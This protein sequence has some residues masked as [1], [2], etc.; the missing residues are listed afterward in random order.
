MFNTYITLND[1][2]DEILIIILKKLK[3]F[4]IVYSLQGINQR[5]NKLIQ[6]RIFTSHLT[7]VKW[8]SDNFI[9]LISCEM[10]LNRF[11]L[12]ILPSIQHKIEWLDLES[13]SMNYILGAGNYPNLH[14]LGLFNINEESTRCLFTDKKVSSDIFKN[15]IRRL[16]I[17][18][19]N[20]NITELA[21]I[22]IFNYILTIFNNLI[23]LTLYESSY[24][25]CVRLCFDNPPPS[26][27]C[28]ST[29]LKLNIKVQWF[30]D[31]LYILD[32]RF[33]QLHTLIVD[34][35]N[36][37][38]IYHNKIQNEGDLP[39]LKCLSLSSGHE[40]NHYNET[41]LPLLNRMSNLEELDLNLTVDFNEIFIDG[42]HLKKNII[43]RM[44]RLK[45]F[46]FSIISMVHIDDS[47]YFP[48]TEDIQQTF[49]DFTNEIISYVDYL[50]EF[51]RGRCHIYSYP[52]L[53]TYYY[54][55]TNNFPGGLFQYVRVVSLYDDTPFEHEFFIQIQK[56]FPF[57]EQLSIVNLKSQNRKQS[58][59]FNNDNQYL[60]PIEYL[61]LNEIDLVNVHDD[62]LEQFLLNTK[63]SLPNN[64]SLYTNYKS[65]E[66][67]TNN[68][69]RDATRFNCRKINYLNLDAQNRNFNSS[70]KEYFPHAKIV[71]FTMF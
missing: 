57:L 17:T 25:N 43:N 66:R 14:T 55:I 4:D 41:I 30:E 45:Q 37:V 18:I 12:Q 22:N 58:Y 28:C 67:V 16:F 56:S 52:S 59:E 65:L 13:S 44:P 15:Q 40:T 3:N 9:D 63:T 6:D 70:L 26:T 35:V 29:L 39:N 11:C 61:Y 19:N 31:C 53:M 54:Y 5:L 32:G 60:S 27:F 64:V 50:S 69:T 7:F 10:I 51:Q 24:K 48:S 38:D 1:L 47:I 36:I 21:I 68:F 46:R 33:N 42:N 23:S 49:I 34:M 71:S 8:S 62:Y 20:N 2:S